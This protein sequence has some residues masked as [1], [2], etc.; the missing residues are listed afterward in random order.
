MGWSSER[1]IQLHEIDAAGV[2]FFAAYFTIAHQAYEQA[3]LSS[4]FDLAVL[5]A[6]GRH[7]LPMVHAEADYRAPLRY[8]DVAVISVT[9]SRIGDRSF[10][11]EY[12]LRGLG[13]TVAHL[14]HIHACVD[15]P[16]GR[17]TALPGE[18]IAALGR[19]L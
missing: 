6:A 1:R 18:L 12:D 3:L 11:M 14:R 19:L 10:T 13:P 15:I 5:L 2:V 17:S 16:S 8:G 9:C 4:G 7:A